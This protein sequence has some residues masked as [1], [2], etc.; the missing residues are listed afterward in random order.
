MESLSRQST[1]R[2]SSRSTASSY[3][4][5]KQS[6]YLQLKSELVDCDKKK[7]TQHFSRFSFLPLD[8]IDK[9]ITRDIVKANSSWTTTIFNPSLPGQIAERAPKVYAILALCEAEAVVWDLFGEGLTDE[10]LPLARVQDKGHSNVLVA[11][12]DKT[13]TNKF[14][15]FAKLGKNTVV[16]NF[17]R[18]Q[19]LVLAPV[20]TTPG[21]HKE[22]NRDAPLPFYDIEKISSNTGSTVYRGK[23]HAA[24]LV[25]RVNYT[26]QIAIKDYVEDKA[27][28][29]EKE[30]LEV[31]QTIK[32]P[33]LIKHTATFEQGSLFYVTFPWA[34]GGNLSEFWKHDP[35][36]LP[37]RDRELFMWSLQQML[38]LVD[39]LWAL[40]R[41]NCRHGDLKPENILHFKTSG[42][43]TTQNSR[44]GTLVIA[45]VGV[46]RVHHQA[47][48]LRHDPTNT[49]AT[50]PCYEA[51]EVEFQKT[52][53]RGRRYDMWSV[54]CMY[55]EFII[56]LLYGY[57]AIDNFRE[58]RRPNDDPFAQKAAYYKR[59]LEG[60]AVIH[61]AVSRG[62]EALRN[63]PRCSEGTGLAALISLIAND[64]LLIEWEQRTE[65]ED[66]RNKFREVLEK[67]EEDPDYLV[68]RIEPPPRVPDV[69]TLG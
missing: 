63:D 49:K 14:N 65:A 66:L 68:R 10:H 2:L 40:H 4:P 44:Y 62:L 27:F 57:K 39:A 29:K 59:T 24:H 11:C 3:N 17:L 32:H 50:T 26:V 1:G 18:N 64:L 35:N 8:A 9:I 22:I 58:L 41:V 31:I 7:K 34:D 28:H 43:S 5:T 15:S 47:T 21:E 16:D 19:W 42:E 12:K 6:L 48:E 33:H 60:T 23:L 55:M 36:A 52:A 46:S 20:L 30:N 61:P 38:G 13:K 45:D 53:P 67:A 25:P 56:W 69:F 51:P 54:G 37:T